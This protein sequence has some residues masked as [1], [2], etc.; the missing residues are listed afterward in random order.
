MLRKM[1]NI[2]IVI[3]STLRKADNGRA[4]PEDASVTS[5]NPIIRC[6]GR[7]P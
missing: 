7:T 4:D 3:V 1:V 6:I 2:A 5:S